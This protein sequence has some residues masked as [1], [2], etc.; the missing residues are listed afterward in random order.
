MD[1]HGKSAKKNGKGKGNVELDVRPPPGFV[2][3]T[4]TVTLKAWAN[5]SR[6]V[7]FTVPL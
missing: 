1:S 2:G 5:P 4:A 7:S 3:G 6:T